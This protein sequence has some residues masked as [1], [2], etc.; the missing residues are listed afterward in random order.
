VRVTTT[1]PTK[2]RD[3]AFQLYQLQLGIAR[4]NALNEEQPEEEPDA[5]LIRSRL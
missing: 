3:D 4:A 5:E 1:N 2:L